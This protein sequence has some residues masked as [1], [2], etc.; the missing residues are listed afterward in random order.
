[1][2]IGSGFGLNR[3]SAAG[4]AY[5]ILNGRFRPA[6]VLDFDSEYYR[7]KGASQTFPSAITHTRA[8][9]ATY[10]DSTGTLQTAA[11]NEPRVGHHVWNGSAW[12]NEGLLHESEARTNLLLRSEEFDDAYWSKDQT[13]IVAN[14]T[15]SPYGALTADTLVENTA[16]S[17]HRLIRST[18]LTTTSGQSYTFSVF[19]KANGRNFFGIQPIDAG[20]PP[21]DN[22]ARYNLSTGVV[23][24][25]LPNVTA[26]IEDVGGG[27]F[28]CICSF[29]S[30]ASGNLG[31]R[32][33]LYDNA[34]NVIY[35]GDG[36]SGIFIWG[37]QLEAA[38]TPSSYIPTSG[39]TVTRAADVLTIPAANLPYPEP[40]VIGPEIAVG[41]PDLLQADWTDN[42][43]DTYTCS[44]AL[45]SGEREIRW[46]NA[47][48]TAGKVFRVSGTISGRTQGALG[49]KLGG[50][51]TNNFTNNG[52][53]EVVLADGSV[54]NVQFVENTSGGL[55]FDGTISNLSV[56]EINP[57]AVS[58][59]MDGAINFADENLAAQQTF[60]RWQL[61]A[62]N[63][64][65][66]DLDTDSTA[67]GEVNFNQAAGGVVDT[68]VTSATALAPSIATTFNIASRHGST[69]I[70]GALNGTALTAD[71]TPVALA[72]LSATDLNLGFDYNGTIKTLRLW[73]Q[74]IGDQGLV[75]ATEPSLV[76]SLSLTFDETENSFI[77]EDWSA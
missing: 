77:V 69:F 33:I 15:N 11:I 57:L 2:F 7:A 45:T 14:S 3:V 60:L 63:F 70:N 13:T 21:S 34:Q 16:N 61:D 74:D 64:I 44:G 40:V 19:V 5:G 73:G 35:T 25:E 65:S 71:T 62:N 22:F 51:A 37:A 58:I 43:D 10:V 66:V 32:F 26:N 6:L 46:I 42:G 47:S 50:G 38:P 31:V 76:P 9:T 36:T 53:F 55:G 18:I 29:V 56:R 28:R 30:P 59:Q 72:N 67:T 17:T 68:V 54:P 4:D 75:E 20:A 41:A 52:A 27:W 24:L 48:I 23:A 49:V 8:S 12:V 39:S 1:M